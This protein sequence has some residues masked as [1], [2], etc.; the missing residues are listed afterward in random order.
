MDAYDFLAGGDRYKT[1]LANAAL[2]LHWLE[3][4]PRWSARG[5]LN[6]LREAARGRLRRP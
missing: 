1:S 6:R 2:S 3:M 5:V 4:T